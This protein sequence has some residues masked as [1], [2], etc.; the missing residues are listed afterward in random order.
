VAPGQHW[1]CDY[2]NTRDTAT[3]VL[4]KA[5]IGG[6]GTFAIAPV[7]DGTVG[8][9][10]PLTTVDGSVA[11]AAITIPVDGTTTV[12]AR[13]GDLAGW[14]LTDAY[15]TVNGGAVVRPDATFPLVDESGTTPAVTK[16]GRGDK[17][18]CYF[19]D[20]ADPT[21]PDTGGKL[22]QTGAPAGVWGGAG[23]V[24]LLLGSLLVVVGR[25]REGSLDA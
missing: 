22:P 15:C 7:V 4:H 24:G 11:S 18:D 8:T 13:E 1:T 9:A 5:S 19:I 14:S 20:T 2:T 21:L 12:G 3:L 6:D 16:V 25:R 10:V 17:V 23:L